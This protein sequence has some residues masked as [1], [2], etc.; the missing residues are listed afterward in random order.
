M[1]II[2]LTIALIAVGT[3]HGQGFAPMDT[4]VRTNELSVDVTGFIRQFV[5]S[6]S[7]APGIPNYYLPTYL[8][9]YKHG[10]G[11]GALRLG[12]GGEYALR[13]DTG[14]Y[15][16]NTDFTNY[17]W[18][19]YFRAGWERRWSLSN[20][21]SCY[22]GIDGLFGTGRGLS[23]NITTHAGRPD[24]HSTFKSFGAGPVLGIQFHLNRRVALYTESS[25]YWIYQETG[26][27]YSYPEDENDVKSLSTSG[28][29]VFSSPIAVWFAV[30][31]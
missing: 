14:G 5:P 13:S 3:F 31:F 12:M 27:H 30:A 17:E 9:A 11:V 6:S 20:R 28:T 25:L 18:R 4:T 26:Q 2:T 24:V 21:W 1:R 16:S 23:H 19:F 15:N 22:A 7:D 29:V 8:L 10:R